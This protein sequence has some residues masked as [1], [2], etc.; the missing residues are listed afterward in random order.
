[1]RFA[2]DVMVDLNQ[3]V[4]QGLDSPL[5]E[6]VDINS[7]GQIIANSISGH[8]YLLTPTVLTD[9]SQVPEP[10]S[11]ALAA[12]ALGLVLRARK[13]ACDGPAIAPGI[14]RPDGD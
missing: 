12:L 6:A 8:A 5:T 4:L 3:L 9:P 13:P 1:V 7:R 2:G 10:S 14:A 11:L